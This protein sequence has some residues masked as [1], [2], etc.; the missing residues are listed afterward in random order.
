MPR[1]RP[2]FPA[3]SGLWGKPTVI[4]NVDTWGN[5]SAILQ[6]GSQW[7]VQYGTEDQ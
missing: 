6:K 4:N 5:V 7:Y 3:Q 1:P 2:P